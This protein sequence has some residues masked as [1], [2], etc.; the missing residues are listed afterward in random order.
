[1]NTR[2]YGIDCGVD[3]RGWLLLPLWPGT[4][5]A[6]YGAD[7]RL[8]Q[9]DRL[10]ALA[11]AGDALRGLHQI[12]MRLYD[13]LQGRL[14]HGDATLRN[15]MYDPASCRAHWYDFNT[16]HNHSEPA[17]ARHAD[18]LRAFLYSALETF[19]DLPVSVIAETVKSAYGDLAVWDHLRSRLARRLLHTSPFHLAQASPPVGR[20]KEVEQLLCGSVGSLESSE[21]QVFD[22]SIVRSVERGNDG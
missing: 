16:V 12:R 7:I 11:A 9:D 1:M 3:S 10:R 5:V 20:R 18:D 13:G 14:S 15:V 17:L 22:G 6:D 8:P 4:V 21:R 2:L 19:F